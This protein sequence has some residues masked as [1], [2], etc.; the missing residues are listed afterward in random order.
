MN[1]Y[2]FIVELKVKLIHVPFA[3]GVVQPSRELLRSVETVSSHC[4]DQSLAS[5]WRQN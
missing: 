5:D 3:E 4:A 2:K 1:E